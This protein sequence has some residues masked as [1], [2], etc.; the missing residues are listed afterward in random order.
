MT[1]P[2]RL[3]FV[4][5]LGAA[6]AAPQPASATREL[7]H[8][9]LTADLASWDADE[10]QFV[11]RITER[12]DATNGDS[13][14]LV[15]FAS[16]V[17]RLLSE[18]S[19]NEIITLLIEV[20]AERRRALSIIRKLLNGTI[21]R[22]SFL[23]FVSEQRWPDAVRRRIAALSPTDLAKLAIALDRADVSELETIL[24]E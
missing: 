10:Q 16:D 18:A 14:R 17:Q 3:A 9:I 7:L 8:R 21:S 11:R 23:S 6:L 19:S 4:Q 20:V 2:D 5:Q 15:V 12:L 13:D 22:T 1:L 24:I